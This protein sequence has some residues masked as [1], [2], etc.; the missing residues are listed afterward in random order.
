MQILN[1]KK[2]LNIGLFSK[3]QQFKQL[4]FKNNSC[5]HMV[6]LNFYYFQHLLPV[7]FHAE[8]YFLLAD[9]NKTQTLNLFQRLHN[10]GTSHRWKWEWPSLPVNRKRRDSLTETSSYYDFRCT[11]NMERKPSPGRLRVLVVRGG[12]RRGAYL[13][14]ISWVVYNSSLGFLGGRQETLY[15]AGRW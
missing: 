2:I 15:H 3:V 4:I 6:Q 11:G 9:Y 8:H 13:G 12:G 5:V 7:L 10:S 1:I 14:A